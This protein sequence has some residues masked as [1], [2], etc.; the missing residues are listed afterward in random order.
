M[1]DEAAPLF[2]AL[3]RELWVIT[4]SA[5]GQRGGL[6]STSVSQA[7]INEQI[8]R[9]TVGLAVHHH[10]ESL[11]HKSKSFVAHLI[12]PNQGDWVRHFGTQSGRDVDKFSKLDFTTSVTNAPILKDAHAWLEC[13][14]ENM[15]ESGDRHWYLAE[16]V[17]AKWSQEFQPLTFQAFLPQA[18][19][20]LM[21]LLKKQ[22]R[23]DSL[24]DSQ[25]VEEWRRSRHS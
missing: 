13:R 6:I 8:P 10:T 2:R 3:D 1:K 20:D 15:M 5:D 24:T 12:A 23:E 22:L 21:P 9:L 14:V 7:P 25:L 16:V 19:D 11:V 4:S 17:D 18:D